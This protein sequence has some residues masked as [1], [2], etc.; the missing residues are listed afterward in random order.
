M[1]KRKG[2][3]WVKSRRLAFWLLFPAVAGAAPGDT[4]VARWKDDR[5]AAFL[6]MFDDGWPSHWQVA[7]PELANRGMIATFYIVPEKGEF[8][9]FEDKWRTEIPPT[10]MV[11]GAHTMTHQGV[12]DIAHAEWE[13]G[14]AANYL[15]ALTARPVPELLSYARPGVPE[16]MWN[17]TDAQEAGILKKNRLIDRPPFRDH[18]AMYHLKTKDEILAL[19]DKAI[20]AKGM[21]YVIWHGVERIEPDWGYQDM[22]AM[23]QEVLF[24]IFDGLKSRSDRRE[25]WITDHVSQHKYETQRNS[26]AVRILERAGNGIEVQL[27]CT[28][29]PAI[30]DAPLTLVTEVPA[31]WKKVR[32]FQGGRSALL[33]V[34][35]GR[36]VYDASPGAVR[37]KPEP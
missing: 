14:E 9:K 25:L 5:Q 35:D 19:A 36:A 37:L 28:A 29:D 27:A 30:Y 6:L 21:E 32:V 23:K 33:Q 15:R 17:I 8:K 11:Y 31:G 4:S 13:I 20:A 18:G 16:G 26:A 1:E 10:G 34:K 12:K 22:W 24:G 7:V 2:V 3:A